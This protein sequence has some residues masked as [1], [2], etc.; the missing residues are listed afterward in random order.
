MALTDE[1]IKA[2]ESAKSEAD[3]KIKAFEETNKSLA[4][5]T[6]YLDDELKKVIEQRD[7]FKKKTDDIVAEKLKEQ[8][9]FK[10][11]YETK[12]PEYESKV[13]EAQKE[14]ERLKSYETKY[15]DFEKKQRETLKEAFTKAGKWVDAFDTKPVED[16]QI[17][18]ETFLDKSESGF[19]PP[20]GGSGNGFKYKSLADVPAGDWQT[21]RDMEKAGIK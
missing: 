7:T 11:L 3:A 5:R 12:L 2:L 4:E 13:T 6:K 14:I 9:D 15:S 20:R 18:A 21:F 1:E 16:L 8:G 19:V 10:T 17:M